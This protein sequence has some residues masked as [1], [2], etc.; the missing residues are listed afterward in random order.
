MYQGIRKLIPNV[1][2]RSRAKVFAIVDQTFFDWSNSLKPHNLTSHLPC[3]RDVRARCDNAHSAIYFAAIATRLR[4]TGQSP[5]VA[6]SVSPAL[7]GPTPDGVPVRMRSP[8]NSVI[9]WLVNE[10]ISATE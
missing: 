7:I 1:R 10:T 8:L 9:A 4:S 5:I 6:S 2:T 3:W